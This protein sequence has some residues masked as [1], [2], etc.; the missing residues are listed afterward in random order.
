MLSVAQIRRLAV[1]FDALDWS[2]V[3][4]L[5]DPIPAD[6]RE[7]TRRLSKML[8]EPESWHVGGRDSSE[9]REAELDPY[10]ALEM[11]LYP[12]GWENEITYSDYGLVITF[13]DQVL[14]R[15]PQTTAYLVQAKRL[16]DHE[17]D[18]R[19]D[20][21]AKFGAENESQRLNLRH[22]AAHLGQDAV[23]FAAYCPRLS[24]FD[25]ASVQTVLQLHQANAS[26]LYTGT[27]FGQEL[28]RNVSEEKSTASEA[29]FW[30]SPVSLKLSKAIDLHRTAFLESLP[31]G[32]FLIAN[33]WTLATVGNEPL[34][35]PHRVRL[36]PHLIPWI[37]PGSPDDLRLNIGQSRQM[38]ELT[39]G[40]ARG[41]M[42]AAQKIAELSGEKVPDSRFRPAATLEVRVTRKLAPELRP[43]LDHDRDDGPRPR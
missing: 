25:E 13:E 31:F 12:T 38:Q 36:P 41:D 3:Q 26:A 32:W 20:L 37:S 33:L 6:E 9:W 39:L 16:Y 29:G 22:L 1:Y 42:N 11:R 17:H 7:V 15:K 30:I 5:A 28:Q 21:N 23:K 19:Y 10:L 35:A 4:D 34:P 8:R 14:N 40:L 43:L 18:P 2:L 24:V 27:P